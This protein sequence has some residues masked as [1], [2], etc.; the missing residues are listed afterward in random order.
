[1]PPGRPKVNYIYIYI[2]IYIYH[3][4]TKW[5]KRVLTISTLRPGTDL[6]LS[7]KAP[8][9]CPTSSRRRSI[10]D[11]VYSE[12]K[13]KNQSKRNI[14]FSIPITH[15]VLT[16]SISKGH[17]GKPA[18]WRP[19]DLSGVLLEYHF[20]L[21]HRYHILTPRL[22]FLGTDKGKIMEKDCWVGERVD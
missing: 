17:E 15:Q 16:T 19:E 14:L 9:S 1:M 3:M 21:I 8:L 12:W 11:L 22:N 20:T 13:I 7:S 5:N 2:Y 4:V 18:T 6:L 10:T